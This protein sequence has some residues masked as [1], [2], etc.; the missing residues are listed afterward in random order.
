MRKP[1][2]T[3]RPPATVAPADRSLWLDQALA[4]EQDP[5]TGATL[6]AR[7]DVCVIGGGFTG[8]WTAIQ[9]KLLDPS[10]EIAVLE[11]AQCG[12]GASG[13]NGGFV[14]TSWSKFGS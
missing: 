2:A 7:S 10:L 11:A 12:A 1:L 5:P 8:L 3:F 14:M 13:R 9:L 6:P 4:S